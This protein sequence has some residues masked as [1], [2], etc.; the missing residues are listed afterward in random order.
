[1]A[2]DLLTCRG[3]RGEPLVLV[4]GLMGRGT[5]WSRQLP[6]LRR[7]GVVYTYDAPWHRG[8]DVDDPHPISTERFVTDLVDAVTTLETPV[9]LV[10]H[11]M[12]AL[13]AWCLAARHPDLVSALVLEDMAP[14]FRGRTTGPWEPWLHAL[15]VEFDSE[16]KVFDEF[17]PVAGR[18][19]LEAFDRTATGWRLHGHTARW[20]EIAAEWGTRDYWQQW[21]A[22]RAPALLIE[23][24][25]SVTPPGQMREMAE[26]HFAA[27][28]LRVPEAGHLIHDEAPR[29]YREAV[30]SFLALPARD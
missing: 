5:T 13:H 22:V 19:F 25:N 24:G 29:V 28:F 2:G 23:A 4:H 26:M 15:P 16:A 30:E 20:I 27:K 7:L 12:G 8:R 1:M 21:R 17:G 10:G 9:R 3:G 11:S 14:D 6:W 18:Y